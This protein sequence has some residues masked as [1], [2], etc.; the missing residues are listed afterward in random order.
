MTLGMGYVI[1][2]L[3]ATQLGPWLFAERLPTILGTSQTLADT[4]HYNAMQV[5]RAPMRALS[6][7]EALLSCE[8]WYVRTIG[9]REQCSLK[10]DLKEVG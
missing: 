5:Y 10:Q 4:V 3:W 1:S 6:K 2:M 9:S 8:S 7:L